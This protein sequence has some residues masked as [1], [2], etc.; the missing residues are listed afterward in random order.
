MVGSAPLAV[1]RGRATGP[2][3]EIVI[4]QPLDVCLHIRQG[5]PPQAIAV[6]D[7]Q[8]ISLE[9]LG[10]WQTCMWTENGGIRWPVAAGRSAAPLTARSPRPFRKGRGP[11]PRPRSPRPA[12]PS[13]RAPGR[14]PPSGSA[15]RC[16]CAPPTSSSATPRSSP[17]PSRWT[18]ASGWWRA[19]TTSPTSS[20]ASA[21]TAGSRG[22]D[23]GRVID[24]GRDDA[25]S[26]VVYEP[27]GVCGLITPWN[28]PLLQATLEGRPGPRSPATRSSSSPASSPPPPRSC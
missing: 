7:A 24:T 18:P 22:T 25:V 26:R 4:R 1:K 11:T 19:S 27:V 15:A 2:H 20:P 5:V 14:A 3:G 28:Y 9:G 21:T 10:A 13:T 16:C 23:A 12:A 8:R 17:A 6:H